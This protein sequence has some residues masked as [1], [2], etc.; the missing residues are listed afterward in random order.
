[1]C[2]TALN[3]RRWP[4]VR[5]IAR[6]ALRFPYS[7]FRT[8]ASACTRCLYLLLDAG[9]QVRHC[10]PEPGRNGHDGLQGKVVFAALDAAHVRAMQSAVIG[11]TFLRKAVL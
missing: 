8:P 5:Q 7:R 11:E 3:R 4:V 10:H 9:K 6:L 1:M 2:Q